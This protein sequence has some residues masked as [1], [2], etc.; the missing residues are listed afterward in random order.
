MDVSYARLHDEWRATSELLRFYEDLKQKR[1]A[2]F[3]SVQA[4]FLAIFGLLV[5]DA[6]GDL[7]MARLTAFVLVAIPPV[8]IGHYAMRVDRRSLAFIETTKTRLVL[9]EQE[10][11][12]RSP[13]QYFSTY[14]ELFGVL[15]QRDPALVEAYARA[16]NVQHDDFQTLVGTPSAHGS[17]RAILRLFWYLWIALLTGATVVHLGMHALALTA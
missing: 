17:E 2:Y 4:A 6:I 9:L 7:S 13:G 1:F 5:K 14:R 16:R 10:W 15:S 12:Q 3:M 8:L 11:E